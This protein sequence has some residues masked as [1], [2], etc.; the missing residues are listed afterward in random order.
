MHRYLRNTL[1]ASSSLALSLI[2]GLSF[3]QPPAQPPLGHGMLETSPA[4]SQ[5]LYNVEPQPSPSPRVEPPIVQK[6]QI[7]WVTS[8]EK[9]ARLDQPQ[10]PGLRF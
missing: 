8:R 4:Q 7:E 2:S 9:P 10:L 1:V 5:Y 3:A 6:L